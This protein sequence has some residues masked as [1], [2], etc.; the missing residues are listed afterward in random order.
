MQKLADPDLRGHADPICEV[1]NHAGRFLEQVIE[2]P[3]LAKT[4]PVGCLWCVK[5]HGVC[6]V[7]EQVVIDDP[8]T[9]HQQAMDGVGP[10][11]YLR[12]VGHAGDALLK[13]LQ[14][15]VGDVP[16]EPGLQGGAEQLLLGDG[17]Y[18]ITSEGI[19]GVVR[20]QQLA[21]DLVDVALANPGT[22]YRACDLFGCQGAQIDTFW[23][24]E[25]RRTG[26]LFIEKTHAVGIAITIE[27]GVRHGRGIGSADQ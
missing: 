23:H 3:G 21:P 17:Q 13:P 10:T 5:Q 27:P 25:G 24:F 14:V 2:L 16:L 8:V 9:V 26:K 22:G 15:D 4:D 12:S 19:G 7:A 20:L 6:A 11:G 1:G 18:C